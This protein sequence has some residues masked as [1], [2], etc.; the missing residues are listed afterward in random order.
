MKN[1]GAFCLVVSSL[2]VALPLTS[3]AVEIAELEQE[4]YPITDTEITRSLGAYASILKTTYAAFRQEKATLSILETTLTKDPNTAAL[5]HSATDSLTNLHESLGE[6]YALF[7]AAND[8]IAVNRNPNGYWN[9][10][11]KFLSA[12]GRTMALLAVVQTKTSGLGPVVSPP[13]AKV[14]VP[15]KKSK[16]RKSSASDWEQEKVVIDGF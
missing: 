15:K 10:E 8:E 2:F 3:F 4:F 1:F 16:K 14:V 9:L 6:T 12:F 7:K 11:K 13:P 5:I